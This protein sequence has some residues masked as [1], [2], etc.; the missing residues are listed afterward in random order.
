MRALPALLLALP[1]ASPLAAQGA[2][3]AMGRTAEGLK[4]LNVGRWEDAVQSWSRE[5]YL[6]GEELVRL[7]ERLESLIP[8]TRSVGGWTPFRKPLTTELWE[9][10]FMVVTFDQGALFLVFDWIHHRERWRLQ[11][12]QV[13]QDPSIFLRGETG[14]SPEPSR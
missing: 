1:F 11:R 6:S 8:T 4:A 14:L 5:G 3:A 13:V 2:P 7:Q 10:H 12:L 9:R